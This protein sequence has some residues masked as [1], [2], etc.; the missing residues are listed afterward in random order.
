MAQSRQLSSEEQSYYSE[1]IRT[2][3]VT[4]K[5]MGISQA[6][7]DDMI[8]VSEGMTAK[9]ESKARLPGAFFLMC[10][11]KALGVEIIIAKKGRCTCHQD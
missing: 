1:I 7:L 5:Q 11:T 10:W 8:G 6:S 3:A 9:W 2:L 4:R